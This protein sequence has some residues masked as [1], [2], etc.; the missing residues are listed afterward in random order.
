MGGRYAFISGFEDDFLAIETPFDP[1]PVKA[2]SLVLTLQNGLHLQISGQRGLH[3]DVEYADNLPG[4]PWQRLQTVLLTNDTQ[5]FGVSSPS[6]M[7]Y[8]RA[9]AD[10]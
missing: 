9:R 7:R 8:F 6:S 1:E 10:P 4:L 2:P 5:A 3:Y